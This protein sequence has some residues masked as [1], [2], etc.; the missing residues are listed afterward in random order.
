[1]HVLSLGRIEGHDE[2]RAH[3]IAY[4]HNIYKAVSCHGL[5]VLRQL[6][7]IPLPL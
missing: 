5:F 7:V 6:V 3:A 4:E 1:M 2:T